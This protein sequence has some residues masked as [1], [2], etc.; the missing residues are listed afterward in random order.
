MTVRRPGA[1]RPLFEWGGG[2]DEDHAVLEG[3]AAATPEEMGPLRARFRGGVHARVWAKGALLALDLGLALGLLRALVGSRE[4]L[5]RDIVIGFVIAVVVVVA[6][7]LLLVLAARRRRH[8]VHRGGLV[9]RA[10]PDAPA[11]V[12]PWES[13]DPG[14]AFITPSTATATRPLASVAQRLVRP[15]GAVVNGSVRA[16]GGADGAGGANRVLRHRPVTGESPF[17]WWQMGVSDPVAV[18]VAVE[19]AMVAEGYPAQELASRALFRE[20]TL[21]AMGKDAAEALDRG[22]RDPLRPT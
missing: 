9:L 6:G 12:V 4:G 13:V 19:S 14:R 11:A 15:P 5:V 16:P 18:L 20:T 1:T 8:D 10:R 7:L 3:W 17:G 22:L 21:R 2:T